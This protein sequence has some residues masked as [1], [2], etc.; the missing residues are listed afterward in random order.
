MK[1][2]ELTENEPD[3]PPVCLS[4]K[5]S[6]AGKEANELNEVPSAAKKPT[7]PPV[8]PCNPT[9]NSIVGRH[10]VLAGDL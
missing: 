8:E 1:E 3:T 4:T 10:P 5:L 2:L 6:L 7:T 9:R